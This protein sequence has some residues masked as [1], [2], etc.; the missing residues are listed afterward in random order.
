MWIEHQSGIQPPA[1]TLRS[2]GHTE[3]M[4]KDQTTKLIF[5]GRL[6]GIRE[7]GRQGNLWLDSVDKTDPQKQRLE[8][9]RTLK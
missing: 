4:N 5:K 8:I 9:G 7:R 1:H 2:F 3:R 6:N